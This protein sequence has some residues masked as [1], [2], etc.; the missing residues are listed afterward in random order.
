LLNGSSVEDWV[1]T[2]SMQTTPYSSLLG[3]PIAG[4]PFVGNS[5]FETFSSYFFLEC[6]K[7]VLV[8]FDLEFHWENPEDSGACSN[9]SGSWLLGGDRLVNN[10]ARGT[11]S[12][13][14]LDDN[15]GQSLNQTAQASKPTSRT[16]MFQ[17]MSQNGIAVTNCSVSFPTVESRISCSD[18]N[19][20]V[21]AMRPYSSTTSSLITP[22]DDCE[23][24]NNFYNQICTRVWTIPYY[25][26]R[27]PVTIRA[28]SSFVVVR[29]LL[30]DRRKPCGGW[31]SR[32]SASRPLEFDSRR[33]ER[34]I[35]TGIQ[36]I[37]DGESRSRVHCRR[38]GIVQ[39]FGFEYTNRSP[40]HSHKRH[41]YHIQR[42]VRLQ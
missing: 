4:I 15:G 7:P 31:T 38:N 41:G 8:N 14:S 19:C 36:Y 17:S 12:L 29:G 16:I 6:T 35:D 26:R 34:K 27:R 9:L 11:C 20:T 37:L 30:D 5:T 24:A 22:L 23:T 40:G 3:N 32:R 2:P 33:D 10:T 42:Y 28:D 25:V 18:G 39:L 13:G 21:T 1:Q